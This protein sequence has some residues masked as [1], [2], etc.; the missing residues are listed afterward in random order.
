M[1]T[2][3]SHAREKGEPSKAPRRGLPIENGVDWRQEAGRRLAL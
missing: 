3:H 2:A 1:D